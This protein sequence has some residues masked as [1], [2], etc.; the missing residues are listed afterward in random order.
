[1]VKSERFIKNMKT[2]HKRTKYCTVKAMIAV[3]PGGGI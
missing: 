1:M 3:S 2:P